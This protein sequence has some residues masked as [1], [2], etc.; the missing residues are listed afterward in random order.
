MNARGV[1]TRPLPSCC[2]ATAHWRLC[3]RRSDPREPPPLRGAL[4]EGREELLAFKQIATLQDAGLEWPPDRETDW[5]AAA[6]AARERGMERL[7][8]R[9]GQVRTRYG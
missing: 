7:A 9:L 8:E 2:A 3:S 4:A 6:A 1:G 5:A